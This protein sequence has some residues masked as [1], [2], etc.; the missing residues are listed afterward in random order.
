MNVDALLSFNHSLAKNFDVSGNIGASLQ[1][2]RYSKAHLESANGL[3]K[4]ISFS[5]P[6]QKVRLS[7]I[8]M[9]ERHR[10]N[11]YTLQQLLVTRIIFI[12]I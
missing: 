7:L 12:S 9:E 1:Q 5:C 11:L 10:F 3:N 4:A 2:S 8:L 6:M